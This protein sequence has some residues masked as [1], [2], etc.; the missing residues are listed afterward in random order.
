MATVVCDWTPQPHHEAFENVVN[1]GIL[2][3]VL[4]CHMN[5]TTV[6]HLMQ[7]GKLDHAPCCVTSDFSVTLKRPTPRVAL[8]VEALIVS[9]TEDRATVEATVTAEGKITSR[10]RGTFVAVR[11]D[12][13]AYHRW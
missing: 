13:P 3:A 2:G 5:W 7:Q 1:G 10:G 4:D 11:P 6:F 12:H 8:R 9:S